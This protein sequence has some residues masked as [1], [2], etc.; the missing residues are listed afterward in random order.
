[1]RAHLLEQ[2]DPA[3]LLIIE[4]EPV[5]VEEPGQFQPRFR[6]GW[7]AG[8]EVAVHR[9]ASRNMHDKDDEPIILDRVHHAVVADPDTP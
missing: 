3:R 1:M 5:R 9:A 7:Q 6:S 2:A 8:S 4:V